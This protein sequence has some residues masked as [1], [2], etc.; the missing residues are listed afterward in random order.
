MLFE[1]GEMKHEF[2]IAEKEKYDISIA[3]LCYFTMYN[4]FTVL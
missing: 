4:S 2:N 1:A 3:L